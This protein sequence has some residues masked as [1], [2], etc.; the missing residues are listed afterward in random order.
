M[1]FIDQGLTLHLTH[2]TSF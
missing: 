1:T 2:N